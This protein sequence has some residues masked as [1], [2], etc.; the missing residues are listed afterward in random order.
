MISRKIKKLQDI[1][2]IEIMVVSGKQ[3][4]YKHSIAEKVFKL[5]DRNMNEK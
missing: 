5:I 4:I 3:C 2:L 1:G